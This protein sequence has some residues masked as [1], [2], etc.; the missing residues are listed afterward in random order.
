MGILGL[1]VGIDRGVD[2][3]LICGGCYVKPGVFV[4]DCGIY[5]I[6]IWLS[7]DT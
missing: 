1:V 2:S 5:L 3:L 6:M 4:L 7:G